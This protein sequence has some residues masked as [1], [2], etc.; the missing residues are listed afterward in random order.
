V[1]TAATGK[2]VQR[3]NLHKDRVLVYDA[4]RLPELVQVAELTVGLADCGRRPIAFAPDGTVLV[5]NPTVGTLSLVTG[6]GQV[7]ETLDLG[8][9]GVK[10]FSFSFWRGEIDGC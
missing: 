1:T 9:G 2:G 8:E 5:P 7:G 10:E 3:E 6:N 4:A